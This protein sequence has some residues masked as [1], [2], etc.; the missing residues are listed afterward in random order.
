M[1]YWPSTVSL[2]WWWGSTAL[3]LL[4]GDG[5]DRAGGEDGCVRGP[6]GAAADVGVQMETLLRNRDSALS[7]QFRL[8]YTNLVCIG[9]HSSEVKCF[10]LI[11]LV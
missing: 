4:P 2:R 3:R 9:H 1:C 10:V 8:N 7:A 11:S 6:G 5:G